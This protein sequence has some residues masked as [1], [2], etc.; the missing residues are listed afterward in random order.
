MLQEIDIEGYAVVDRLRVSFQA[1]LNLLTGE[2][3]SGKSIIVDSL[4]LLFG[5]R[6]T[7]DSVRPGS[8]RARVSGRFDVPAAGPVQRMLADSGIDLDGDDLIIE[9][10]ILA[11]GKSRAYVNGTPATLALLRSLAQHLG[12]IHGQH[13]QQTLLASG[14]Q[15]DLLDGYAGTDGDTDAIGALFRGWQTARD[16]LE[17]IRGDE[18][19]RLRRIDLLRYQTEEINAAGVRE[20]EDEE[21]DRQRV[22]LV[23][24]ERLRDSGFT[25][26]DSLYD[27]S[28]SASSQLKTAASSLASVAGFDDRL[29]GL[30]DSLEEA[31]TIVDDVAFELRGWLE[32]IEADPRRQEEVES[33]LALLDTLKRKYGPGLG[34]VL[35]HAARAGEELA[36]LD[37]SDEEA[38]RIERE[39]QTAAAEYASQSEELSRRRRVAAD[40]LSVRT[41]TELRELALD[42]ARFVIALDR[43]PTWGARGVDRA[44]FLFAANAGQEPKPLGQGASGGELSRLALAL[45][46]CLQERADSGSYRRALVF[47]EIDTGVGG[48]VAE[49]IGRRLKILADRNQVL[50]VT[51]LPQIARFADA[52]YV[53]SKVEKADRTTA[54]VRELAEDRRVEELARMLSGSE[55]TEAAMENA[56]QLLSSR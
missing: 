50:C 15:L 44:A 10:Q 16:R 18:Q 29:G 48:R 49:A 2:T 39:L 45:K 38:E 47:D 27:S 8:R 55:V 22:R 4:A 5:N 17:Q 25:A 24:A 11:S 1:G 54:S 26:C 7:A 34:A 36:V 42:K 23:H 52:H 19:E 46:T 41:Q 51:H 43:L 40:A 9:R 56:R 21:L 32:K 53:V 12:D 28:A 30:A 33:R 35:D 31:R 20:G 6:A 37:R 3:G 13:E 14:P